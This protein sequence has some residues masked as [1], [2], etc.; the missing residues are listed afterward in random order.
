MNIPR[1]RRYPMRPLAPNLTTAQ[2]LALRDGI[3]F[4]RYSYTAT[5]SGTYRWATYATT[6]PRRIEGETA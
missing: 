3:D 6:P 5:E 1:T 2:R 4:V